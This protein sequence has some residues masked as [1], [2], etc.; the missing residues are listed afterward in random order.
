[1]KDLLTAFPLKRVFALL[2]VLCSTMNLPGAHAAADDSAAGADQQ[3]YV[4]R[5]GWHIDIGMAASEL[6]P[7]LSQIA[8]DLP[9]AR[10]VFFGFADKH[11]LLAKNHHAPVLLSALFPGAGIV[12]T[13]GIAN[14]P[15]QAFGEK[16]VIALRVTPQQMRG[17]QSFIWRSLRTRDEMLKVY[18]SGPYDDS[19][20]F[21]A[22]RKYSAFHTC[23]TWGAEALRSAG[24]HVHA[25]GVI[26]AWQ[27]WTQARRLKHSQ[28]QA[29]AAGASLR[30]GAAD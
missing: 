10:Y 9:S 26:F 21:L 11:Y 19:V 6:P 17:L 24:F 18:E 12:L 5:R 22:V 2:T 3:V 27:L 25:G 16:Q 28:D 8:F 29:E 15:A 4:V 30:V 13:T 23:N 14:S 7:P 1:M 20:Y